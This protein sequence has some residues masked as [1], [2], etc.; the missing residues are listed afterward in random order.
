M[1]SH[2]ERIGYLQGA[3]PQRPIEPVHSLMEEY[4]RKG[5]LEVVGD[6]IVEPEATAI[7]CPDCGKHHDG[8]HGHGLLKVNKVCAECYE[9]RRGA[10]IRN[11]W[12]LR[13]EN[14]ELREALAYVIG[15]A[16]GWY[17]KNPKRIETPKMDAARKLLGG[18]E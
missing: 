18:M 17:W 4:V 1:K 2:I 5:T 3:S 12:K 8:L 9:I 16:D 11:S 15:E 6:I 7:T 14:R 10:G 13:R